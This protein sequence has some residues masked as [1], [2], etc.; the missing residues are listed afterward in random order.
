METVERF[1]IIGGFMEKFEIEKV[2]I[3][4]AQKVDSWERLFNDFKKL[5][6]SEFKRIRDKLD[7][8]ESLL[9][10]RPTWV[11]TTIISFLFGI[12]M[13]LATLLVK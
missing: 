5:S 11:I 4:T 6:N 12:C 10:S 7:D 2:V 9:H 13:I 3:E 8:I 1:K